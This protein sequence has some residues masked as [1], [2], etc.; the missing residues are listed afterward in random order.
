MS[1]KIK[2]C[3]LDEIDEGKSKGFNVDDEA[4]FVVKQ[5]GSYYAYENTCPH[6]GVEL[7]WTE[8]E[9][10]D[11]DGALIQ[12]HLH[13]ALFNIESGKCIAGP[14]EGDA[15]TPIKTCIEDDS[16]YVVNEN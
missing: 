8:D 13:G 4:L 5:N 1:N 14:C 15:L 3:D 16:L 9:F 7:E 6:L 12:C 10:L 11:P 2:L